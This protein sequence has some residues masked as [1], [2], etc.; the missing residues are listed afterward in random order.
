MGFEGKA[1][2]RSGG[3]GLDKAGAEGKAVKRSGGGVR[4]GDGGLKRPSN[5]G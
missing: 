2:R 5:L 4:C 3:G 1:V